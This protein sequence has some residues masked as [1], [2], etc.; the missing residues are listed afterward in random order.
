NQQLELDL[1][2]ERVSEITKQADERNRQKIQEQSDKVWET[3]E[4][5]WQNFE[6]SVTGIEERSKHLDYVV[7]NKEHV[8]STQ[9]T[10]ESNQ[11]EVN[12]LSNTVLM[13]LRE[14]SNTSAIA[15]SDKLE[16][17]NKSYERLLENLREKHEKTSKDLEEIVKALGDV[18]RTKA[19]LYNLKQEVTGFYVWAEDLTQT[20]NNLHN[21][22][23]KVDDEI[24]K[25]R[26]FCTDLKARYVKS[27]QI[28]PSDVAQELNQLE[29]LT[30][31]IANAMEEKAREFKKARTVRTDYLNEVE[32]VQNWIKEAEIK[33]QDR[34]VEPQV[35]HE[36]LQQIQSEIAGTSDKLEKLTRNGRAIMEKTKDDE[37][38]EMIQNTINNLTDQLAQVRTWLEEKKQQV[39][40]ILDAWQRF[41]TLYQAVMTW[42][43][44]KSCKVATKNL[45]DM[46]KELDHIGSVT[47]VGD[48][49]Q[50]MEQ[51]EEAKVEVEALILERNGLL[52]ETSEEWEQCEKKI[53]DVKG[54][55]EKT[56]AALESQQNKKKPLRDQHGLREKML[57]DIQ[58]QKTKISL[59]VEKLQTES[60]VT[61]SA[62]ALLSDLDDLSAAIR[63]QIQQLE[64]AIAQVDAYQT[65]VQQLRQAIV[66]VEQQLRQAMAPN[67]APHDRERAL[68]EQQ[69]A[70]SR[71]IVKLAGEIQ[72]LDPYATHYALLGVSYADV[73]AGRSKSQDR[74]DLQPTLDAEKPVTLTRQHKDLPTIV[75]PQLEPEKV[76]R[77]KSPRRSRSPKR[78][79]KKEQTLEEVPVI[80]EPVESPQEALDGGSSSL[81]PQEASHNHDKRRHR[82][83]S[84]MTL[85]SHAEKPQ[86]QLPQKPAEVKL[87][88]EERRAT[89][90]SKDHSS[91]P[92]ALPSHAEN[93]KEQRSKPQKAPESEPKDRRPQPKEH[94]QEKTR[95]R[96]QKPKEQRPKPQKVAEPEPSAEAPKDHR[97]ASHLGVQ[98]RKRDRSPSPMW[99]PGQTSYAEVLRGQYRS[100]EERET[101]PEV[102]P[103]YVAQEEIVYQPI[104]T[105]VEYTTALPQDF[106]MNH[107][108]GWSQYPQP[109]YYGGV[110][111]EMPQAFYPPAIQPVQANIIEYV[112]PMPDMVN[113]IASGQQLIS[114]GLGTYQSTSSYSSENVYEYEVK[115][116]AKEPEMEASYAQ[117]LSQGLENKPTIQP[118]SLA[119]T[120]RQSPTQESPVYGTRSTHLDETKQDRRQKTDK[121]NHR[122]R[123][124][125]NVQSQ[126]RLGES[127]EPPTGGAAATDGSNAQDLDAKEEVVHRDEIDKALREISL[128]EKLPKDK[129][130][131][132]D[133]DESKTSELS[134]S[135]SS[136]LDR[137]IVSKKSKKKKAKKEK[138]TTPEA[139]VAEEGCVDPA[140]D[141]TAER[142]KKKKSK[143]KKTVEDGQSNSE[144]TVTDPSDHTGQEKKSKKKNK[145]KELDGH[146]DPKI[147]TTQNIVCQQLTETTNDKKALVDEPSEEPDNSQHT[148]NKKRKNKKKNK[149]VE[150]HE[151][152]KDEL[153]DHHKNAVIEFIETEKSVVAANDTKQ[154]ESWTEIVE[155][156]TEI[157]ET[158]DH[159]ED[160][161]VIQEN[162]A[163][164]SNSEGGGDKHQESKKKQKKK[165]KKQNTEIEST[166]AFVIT[167]EIR[168]IPED[169][170]TEEKVPVNKSKK[171]YDKRS[172]TTFMANEIEEIK[173]QETNF[174]T[175]REQHVSSTLTDSIEQPNDSVEEKKKNAPESELAEGVEEKLEIQQVS[176]SI[177]AET[178]E[179]L[180][181]ETVEQ[182]KDFQDEKNLE[183][184][185]LEPEDTLTS[186]SSDLELKD[187]KKKNKRHKKKVAANTEETAI[188]HRE[189]VPEK[190]Q[191]SGLSETNAQTVLKEV[192]KDSVPIISETTVEEINRE[193]KRKSKTTTTVT[194]VTSMTK[195]T[196]LTSDNINM[197][198][199]SQETVSEPSQ[200]TIITTNGTSEK[201]LTSK[202]QQVD[203]EIQKIVDLKDTNKIVLITHEE[204]RMKPVVTLKMEFVETPIEEI[205]HTEEGY[206]E[207]NKTI[208]KDKRE[209]T[210]IT[211]ISAVRESEEDSRKETQLSRQ[212]GFDMSNASKEFI[213]HETQIHNGN[214]DITDSEEWKDIEIEQVIFGSV[215]ERPKR[216]IE[217]KH[218]QKIKPEKKHK[219][220]DVDDKSKKRQGLTLD[221]LCTESAEQSDSPSVEVEVCHQQTSLSRL[222]SVVDTEITNVEDVMNVLESRKKKKIRSKK[223]HDDAGESSTKVHVEEQK[224]TNA[225]YK[226]LPIDSST[227]IFDILDE[228]IT[229]SDEETEGN[230]IQTKSEVQKIQDASLLQVTDDAYPISDEELVENDAYKVVENMPKIPSNADIKTWASIVDETKLEDNCPE[231]VIDKQATECE[232]NIS[233]PEPSECKEEAKKGKKKHKK[234]KQHQKED[235]IETIPTT[236]S[237]K[238][239]ANETTVEEQSVDVID[240]G[241]T[242]ILDQ[243]KQETLSKYKPDLDGIPDTIPKPKP[244]CLPRQTEVLEKSSPKKQKA[245]KEDKPKKEKTPPPI[246][247]EIH[248]E[249]ESL[250]ETVD[251]SEKSPV[252]S[253]TA[254][255]FESLPVIPQSPEKPLPDIKYLE[256]TGSVVQSTVKADAQEENISN[257]LHEL[258]EETLKKYNI[259]TDAK[260]TMPDKDV[261]VKKAKKSKKKGKKSV[262]F[263]ETP[264]V[265]SYVEETPKAEENGVK[266]SPELTEEFVVVPS[267]TYDEVKKE[268]F[269]V[270]AVDEDTVNISQTDH[271]LDRETSQYEE[272]TSESNQSKAGIV[273][274]FINKERQQIEDATDT[275]KKSKKKKSKGKQG[276]EEHTKEEQLESVSVSVDINDTVVETVE[277]QQD[278]GDS[279]KKK[280]SKKKHNVEEKPKTVQQNGD[281]GQNQL[282]AS[283]LGESWA[284]VVATEDSSSAK[285]IETEKMSSEKETLSE[286]FVE[287]SNEQV[288][289]ESP[290]LIKEFEV[291]QKP[292][293]SHSGGKSKKAKKQKNKNAKS[294]VEEAKTT[295]VDNITVSEVQSSWAN[296]VK[297]NLDLQQ[298]VVDE[299]LAK[300]DEISTSHEPEPIAEEKVK[301]EEKSKKK[302]HKKKHH[303][304]EKSKETFEITEEIVKI[305]TN[306][307]MTI[308]IKSP[309]KEKQEKQN[310]SLDEANRQA[311]LDTDVNIESYEIISQVETPETKDIQPTTKTSWAD[312]TKANLV[313]TPEDLK[314]VDT[315]LKI[316]SPK[317]DNVTKEE[318]EYISSDNDDH[319][320]DK[321]SK[322]KRKQK[323]KKHGEEE[324]PKPAFTITEEILEIPE[325]SVEEK[326]EPPKKEQ[327]K[328]K[329]KKE[330]PTVE[331]ASDKATKD[332]KHEEESVGAVVQPVIDAV[333]SVTGE[334]ESE[335]V[336]VEKELHETVEESKKSK[337]KKDKNKS[338]ETSL[339]SVDTSV[340]EEIESKAES[341]D[342][343]ECKTTTS[344]SAEENVITSTEHVEH[345]V[346]HETE[347]NDSAIVENQYAPY[348]DVL[349]ESSK[350]IDFTAE[351]LVQEKL[352]HFE[353]ERRVVE[354]N[355]DLTDE[356]TDLITDILDDISFE[357]NEVESPRGPFPT[358][359]LDLLREDSEMTDKDDLDFNV[360]E[361]EIQA[362]SIMTK[363][364]AQERMHYV[365]IDQENAEATSQKTQSVTDI[366]MQEELVV[367][368]K[369]IEYKGLPVD[370][371]AD[372]FLEVLD[373]G[374]MTFKDEESDVLKD[375][376]VA[377]IN[378]HEATTVE[379]TKV[380]YKGL[381]V[382]K[383]TDLFL[384]VLDDG[385]MS[386]EDEESASVEDKSAADI[387]S[388]ETTTL[389]KAKVEYKGLPVDKST[390][391]FLEVLD[392]G[393]MSFEDEEPASVEDKSAADTHS[394]ETTTVEKA[395]VEYK[396]LPVDKSTELFLDV[397]DEG[398]MTF[399][400]E[401]SASVE[402]KSAADIQPKEATTLE[403]TKVD[404]KGLPVD[405]STDLFLEVLDE[406]GMSFE[407]EEPGSIED[408]LAAVTHLKEATAVEQTKVEYKGLPVDESTDLFLDVL[409][410]GGMS[411][412]EE[413]C[414]PLEDKRADE[415]ETTTIE[416]IKVAS[417]GLPV[418]SVDSFLEALKDQEAMSIE[419]E[420][421]IALESKASAADLRLEESTTI[422]KTKVDYKGLPVDKSTDLFLEIL[423]EGGMSF[424]DEESASVEGESADARL[425]ETATVET[426]KVA[427]K[428]LPIDES[429]DS[430]LEALKDQEGMSLEEEEYIALESKLPA[431]DIRVEEATDVEKTKVEYKGL[432]VDK[433]TDLFLDVLDEGGMSFEDEESASVENKP[434]VDTQLKE[435]TTVDKTKV[436]YKGLPVDKTTD[437]FIDLLDEGGMSFEDEEES[438]EIAH[439]EPTPDQE[440]SKA[441]EAEVKPTE[442]K[443]EYK[444]LPIN[445]STNL[446]MDV[447]DQEMA[448]ED[449]E[450][451]TAVQKTDIEMPKETSVSSQESIQQHIERESSKTVIYHDTELNQKGE[452]D[453]HDTVTYEAK[454]VIPAVKADV[455]K[456]QELIVMD[457]AD[458]EPPKAKLFDE[459][460]KY[461]ILRLL[462]AE[463]R[464]YEQQYLTIE[465][466][467]EEVR[468]SSECEKTT[469]VE[470]SYIK[471]DI[472]YLLKAEAEWY[473]KLAQE[474]QIVSEAE[475]A[476]VETENPTEHVIPLIE[477][478]Q[479][480]VSSNADIV[481]TFIS[482]EIKQL[483]LES[484]MALAIESQKE[485]S[486]VTDEK[487]YETVIIGDTK[488]AESED[489][490]TEI[491][492]ISEVTSTVSE[493]TINVE[494]NQSI[495][496]KGSSKVIAS[497]E[498]TVAVTAQ[499]KKPSQFEAILEKATEFIPKSAKKSELSTDATEFVPK[500]MEFSRLNPNAAEFVPGSLEKKVAPDYV[501]YGQ[502]YKP[503]RTFPEAPAWE[504]SKDACNIPIVEE[505]YEAGFEIPPD[506]ASNEWVNQ[507]L[508][509]PADEFIIHKEESENAVPV[510]QDF[511]QKRIEES[512]LP[513]EVVSEL[514]TSG[515]TDTHTTLS[516]TGQAEQTTEWRSEFESEETTQRSPRRR[517]SKS[518]RPPQQKQQE[519]FFYVEPTVESTNVWEALKKGDKTYA[520]VVATGSPERKAQPEVAQ[521]EVK[522]EEI[523]EPQK[524]EAE[525]FAGS[526]RS[527]DELQ[528]ETS[529]KNKRKS[530]KRDRS[531]RPNND[532]HVEVLQE[533]SERTGEDALPDVNVAE[534]EEMKQNL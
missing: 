22:Q 42:N 459:P 417:K 296:V 352:Q 256:A 317:A 518:P 402:D 499:E 117:I 69:A 427:Y 485:T 236:E 207:E 15:L 397:L 437:L 331:E 152:V 524:I 318:L 30:E 211:E 6:S 147:E 220:V 246:S 215:K 466:E 93:P 481:N 348:V 94:T 488:S 398:G 51:A 70:T 290:D 83:P 43:A 229:I 219:E 299:K 186:A 252:L 521:I 205:E 360:T 316:E 262:S 248:D 368:G 372:L 486:I 210:K 532:E 187:D 493:E 78:K 243:L 245:K 196:P 23:F 336:K 342:A 445:K 308:P 285:L 80:V 201:G 213:R 188:N 315:E 357:D 234:K 172:A 143:K 96:P 45:S 277:N 269:T 529:K 387:H 218:S 263:E 65:E 20:E 451:E 50:K 7:R 107:P 138:E 381:P 528:V 148:A 228:P 311:I 180:I 374:E 157:P 351:F 71:R 453:L 237:S 167:E 340:V 146:N 517:K 32:D 393:G 26:G 513:S 487:E 144:V 328:K 123:Q 199:M 477:P 135:A 430:F 141:E 335:M 443:E 159:I 298:D 136:K 273:Q 442:K 64:A 390:E 90:Q 495:E 151:S 474:S 501:D 386:F 460:P 484:N 170:K 113:F 265:I 189:A 500:G 449:S 305:P 57:A 405:E 267:A 411:F 249:Q 97:A 34:S 58:I 244:A 436:E 223:T 338:K 461:D 1:L 502:A 433:S 312:V 185:Q 320:E 369:K 91:S 257:L 66:H 367:V 2:L 153:E 16:Q 192:I 77:D 413:E 496:E 112:Q 127:V 383:S 363:F 92:M 464:W 193:N 476:T 238:E 31:T 62:T 227:S 531:P 379:K 114:S 268:Q 525:E 235:N 259:E 479:D 160:Q 76:P 520:D 406:G 95:D 260:E 280:K 429:T 212:N 253:P 24:N 59:S 49:P 86:E 300:P 88:V 276:A 509:E 174:V 362:K 134:D 504:Y 323:K 392:E 325:V 353:L 184:K 181:T 176:E 498:E 264:Q 478:Q 72:R 380:E 266:D 364:L 465:Q 292:E 102:V 206:F 332:E 230:V 420:H 385:G 109:E 454:K 17:L 150:D 27:Q 19:E 457:Y 164:A 163:T 469:K 13:F 480:S 55:I 490:N 519:P 130:Q 106:V 347:T 458:E 75:Q 389:E 119:S 140:S 39:G 431:T 124:N 224:K 508:H 100:S 60:R 371:S 278:A 399:E 293:E 274:D 516:W 156:S 53:K 376:P 533:T 36:H 505:H 391:L 491:A 289:V 198:I 67:Y 284:A 52:Q 510:M 250:E 497:N 222:D 515:V 447:L 404:Y 421:H 40:D 242:N 154:P 527:A 419:D 10:I 177:N 281:K 425:K 9:N 418:E 105:A 89:S 132:R 327:K 330:K 275:S 35:L 142:T 101:P 441:V 307:E 208:T 373:D 446:F 448:W 191:I 422:E 183:T 355:K 370:K 195:T 44:V 173:K 463:T 412:E 131:V 166:P 61:E 12:Q 202:E 168:K 301:D 403:K 321:K 382:D 450:D 111:Q 225:D 161:I 439:T 482:E 322:K 175:E 46:A 291:V 122:S 133:K 104:A 394:K 226:G 155:K 494:S 333:V 28:V 375:K 272:V 416:T 350:V 326:P 334:I 99:L 282:A 37:E 294:T 286:S 38:K 217:C 407:D 197:P 81:E 470:E 258:K 401:E 149:Q 233:S 534:V 5:R 346:R 358:P 63:Q 4:G 492:T 526:E 438:T 356:S 121:E 137:V 271:H 324:T 194:T 190:S 319:T 345:V 48:L 354:E 343:D 84:P 283:E 118:S 377:D 444:G 232:R 462:E 314:P 455:V 103:T 423:D 349:K 303:A 203:A 85:S 424:E 329:H 54:W 489:T 125:E 472:V 178:E 468:S 120:Q 512:L 79:S 295:I 388:K 523:D 240:T 179:Q 108:Q 400:D 440:E 18:T 365:Y 408:K 204:V 3:F 511:E 110:P 33:V 165:P 169:V 361:E 241:I 507:M 73:A 522:V 483:T 302:K 313:D 214:E 11:N 456:M 158:S 261:S 475:N 344:I 396:G 209:V 129:S 410:E 288:K 116:K 98:E 47:S 74:H 395:K 471:Y 239:D 41:L 247:I 514:K 87:T 82:S 530:R 128:N 434:A 21:L 221:Y 25:V 426:I 378:L 310:I 231:A 309:K 251:I 126:S 216:I 279:K 339:P 337:K 115:P 56:K 473:E 467:K 359:N 452:E 428:G 287:I 145:A 200:T 506:H 432:P 415:E 14:C 68:R 414:L 162:L 306:D 304:E 366:P 435:T 297:S 139:E 182:S 171:A 341:I 409:D 8:I 503:P 29:L 255:T 384:E 270:S 254:V